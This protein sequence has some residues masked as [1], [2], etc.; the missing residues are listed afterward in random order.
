MLES[1]SLQLQAKVYKV[2]KAAADMKIHSRGVPS[3]NLQTVMIQNSPKLFTRMKASNN[4][5]KQQKIQQLNCLQNSL[6]YTY[7][8]MKY[9][10]SLDFGMFNIY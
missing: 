5:G 6:Q 9:R 10:Q 8:D 7:S 2:S 3:V 4:I 1:V